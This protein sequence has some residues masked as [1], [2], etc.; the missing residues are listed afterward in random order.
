MT[1]ALERTQ[2]AQIGA[3]V[4]EFLAISTNQPDSVTLEPTQPK[5]SSGVLLVGSTFFH[6]ATSYITPSI[7]LQ[8]PRNGCHLVAVEVVLGHTQ[9]KKHGA[10]GFRIGYDRT[11]GLLLQIDGGVGACPVEVQPTELQPTP[12]NKVW[13][14]GGHIELLCDERLYSSNPQQ[15]EADEWMPANDILWLLW[16]RLEP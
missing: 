13:V 10:R 2:K 7:T 16:R 6:P 8:V 4:A 11:I 14:D 15:Q 12:P 1:A 5:H 9:I 3:A